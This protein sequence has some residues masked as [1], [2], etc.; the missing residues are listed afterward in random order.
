M[1]QA[2]PQR[3]A[4]I[5]RAASGIG[6]AAALAPAQTG[7]VVVLPGRRADA[8]QAVAR[9][10]AAQG[11]TARSFVL[12]VTYSEAVVAAAVERGVGPVDVLVD[13]AGINV[14]ARS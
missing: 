9:E 13:S 6:R 2:G 14:T 5:T 7:H 12:D 4:W 1:K 8:L 11:G 3:I 10:V